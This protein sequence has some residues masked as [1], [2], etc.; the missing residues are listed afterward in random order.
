MK[1][2]RIDEVDGLR[3]IAM[4]MVIAQHCGLPFGWTGVW[5]FFVISGY[6][7]SRNFLCEAYTNGPVLQEYKI[8]ML[9]RF[10]R[11]VPVYTFYIAIGTGIIF[12][13]GL[14]T[15]GRAFYTSG[16]WGVACCVKWRGRLAASLMAVIFITH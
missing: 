9:R 15:H 7:I 12:A 1:I 11:I 6:V 5:L 8:F 4:T 16:I 3:A 14:S 2:E 13:L 10:F